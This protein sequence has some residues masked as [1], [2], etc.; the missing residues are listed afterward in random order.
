MCHGIKTVAS[1]DYY[2]MIDNDG[3]CVIMRGLSDNSEFTFC[4][5]KK[6]ISIENFTTIAAEI[7]AFWVSPESHNYTYMFLA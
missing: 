4:A 3:H 1:Y 2:L 5:L 6:D 7:D